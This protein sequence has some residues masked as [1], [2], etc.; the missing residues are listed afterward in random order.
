[1]DT[2]HGPLDLILDAVGCMKK[3]AY[4]LGR[5]DFGTFIVNCNRYGISV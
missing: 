5:W 4:P 1:V 3:R 2:P